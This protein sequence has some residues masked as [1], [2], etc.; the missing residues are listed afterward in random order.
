MGTIRSE[1]RGRW[2]AW[3]IMLALG[4]SLV[5]APREARSQSLPPAS[6]AYTAYLGGVAFGA[7]AFDVALAED[8]YA[9]GFRMRT[10]GFLGW[11]L[12]WSQSVRASGEVA[13]GLR[14]RWLRSDGLWR[15]RARHI[16]I[17]FAP[18]GA[19][20]ASADPAIDSEDR[21]PVPLEATRG[22]TDLM[23]AIVEVARGL[24]QGLLCDRRVPVFDGRRRYD[25]LFAH[26]GPETLPQSAYAPIAGEATRC[27]FQ[28]EL[29]AGGL[30]TASG[31]RLVAPDAVSRVWFK[32]VGHDL[33]PIPVRLETDTNFGTLV[34]HLTRVGAPVAD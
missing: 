5:M 33:P 25:V 34:I 2:A 4:A 32:R 10:E 8:A 3:A 27:S 9:L 24:D 28:F 7:M 13:G 6:L 22:A 15:G 17:V 19:T 14:P 23:S 1:P 26:G 12:P 20:V 16:E 11:L 31:T 21:D 30:R 18:E 29:I